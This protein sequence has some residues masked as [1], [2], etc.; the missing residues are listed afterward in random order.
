MLL[1]L[2]HG[3]VSRSATRSVM[4]TSPEYIAAKAANGANSSAADFI[5]WLRT[6]AGNPEVN[7]HYTVLSYEMTPTNG[8]LVQGTISNPK[9]RR[10][11]TN[12]L[13]NTKTVMRNLTYSN[14]IQSPVSGDKPVATSHTPSISADPIT[15]RE[16]LHAIVQPTNIANLSVDKLVEGNSMVS[17]DRNR[18][19]FISA[20]EHKQRAKVLSLFSQSRPNENVT[21]TKDKMR[22]PTPI[23]IGSPPPMGPEGLAAMRQAVHATAAP[24]I[25]QQFGRFTS[26]LTIMDQLTRTEFIHNQ[27]EAIEAKAIKAVC[28]KFVRAKAMPGGIGDTTKNAS[29]AIHPQKTGDTMKNATE[30][31]HPQKTPGSKTPATTKPPPRGLYSISNVSIEEKEKNVFARSV[32]VEAGL[33]TVAPMH[34]LVTEAE[35]H[36]KTLQHTILLSCNRVML[37]AAWMD[38]NWCQSSGRSCGCSFRLL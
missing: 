32:E 5:Q 26:T 17:R 8:D 16:D 33:K 34:Q 27:R 4:I 24:M 7:L 3:Y 35:E 21:P 2:K 10:S 30:A 28:S 9:G 1:E 13:P 31:I 36:M 25:K 18:S 29:E 12:P 19:L 37:G 14:T 23:Q 22:K 15:Q 11:K 38:E 20:Q 6:Q